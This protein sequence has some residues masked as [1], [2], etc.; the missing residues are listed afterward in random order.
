MFLF[1]FVFF[2]DLGRQNR[3]HL[4]NLEWLFLYVAKG[5]ERCRSLMKKINVVMK[6]LLPH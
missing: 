4:Y 5:N 2:V 1:A 3:C 6:P